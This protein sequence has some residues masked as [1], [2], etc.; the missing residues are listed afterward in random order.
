MITIRSQKEVSEPT[1]IGFEATIKIADAAYEMSSTAAVDDGM[2][3][4]GGLYGRILW[5]RALFRLGPSLALEQQ[6]FVSADSSDVAIA[7]QLRGTLRPAELL[8]TPQF[9]GCP[10]SGYRDRGFC[11]DSQ[12]NGGRLSWLPHVVGPRIIADTNG[13]YRE[14]PFGFSRILEAAANATATVAP[15]T[16]AFQLTQRPAILIFST[17]K[18]KAEGGYNL[19]MFLAGL[20]SPACAV[21]GTE[22]LAMNVETERLAE[23]A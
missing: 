6:M 2:P 3:V 12:E 17:D 13:H 21:P 9:A 5:P 14:E 16:F 18:A 7:W 1:L 10:M 23:A 11:R 22:T 15:G 4:G 20:L 19:G 8:I